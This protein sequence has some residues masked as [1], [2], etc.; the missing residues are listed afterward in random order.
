MLPELQ[1]SWISLLFSVTFWTFEPCLSDTS[2]RH[3]RKQSRVSRVLIFTGSDDLK[4]NKWEQTSGC[5]ELIC[6]N[7]QSS[8]SLGVK[9]AELP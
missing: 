2:L 4:T 6:V 5:Y 7:S 8:R 9:A 1:D 3:L